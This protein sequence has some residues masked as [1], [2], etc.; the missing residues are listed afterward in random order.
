M[1]YSR[2]R[3]GYQSGYC[4]YGLNN[5]LV[6]GDTSGVAKRLA[7]MDDTDNLLQAE[8]FGADGYYAISSNGYCKT[9]RDFRGD[10]IVNQTNYIPAGDTLLA[11][12]HY[13][14]DSLGNE[15]RAW[16]QSDLLKLDSV[17]SRGNETS[18]TYYNLKR[19]PITYSGIH[20]YE[21]A[22]TYGSHSSRSV[23]RYLDEQG[24]VILPSGR[25][26]SKCIIQTDSL[27]YTIKAYYYRND[28]LIQAEERLCDM[29]FK[30]IVRRYDI[31]EAGERSRS[32][33]DGNYLRAECGI[34]CRQRVR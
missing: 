13:E 25:D 15:L 4:Y 18:V 14:K 27:T 3:Y 26:W 6:A 34:F 21:I 7:M 2:S 17:D 5:Q 28:T 16:Y 24:R 32:G 19:Q 10:E 23:T 9:V 22:Y 8:Y 11:K 29:D 1:T 12:F 20:R 33:Y 31:N 30:N